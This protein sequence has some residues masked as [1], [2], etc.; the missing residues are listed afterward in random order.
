MPAHHRPHQPSSF[1]SPRPV[2]PTTV[3]RPPTSGYMSGP[4]G[5][6]W[7]SGGFLIRQ[8]SPSGSSRRSG[9]LDGTAETA[10]QPTNGGLG[11]LVVAILL[12]LAVVHWANTPSNDV[13]PTPL[14]AA[15]VPAYQAQ[16]RT[17]PS[18]GEIVQVASFRGSASARAEVALLARRGVAARV[19]RSDTFRPYRAGFYVVYVGPFAASPAGRT[20]AARMRG[21][22]PGSRIQ[23]VSHR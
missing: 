18:D 22:L 12:A 11:G 4:E 13:Q 19:L 23:I 5:Y 8:P 6:G 10:A 3:S 7:H 20:A 15:A 17:D 1:T 9:G 16:A 14:P 21:T 2:Q